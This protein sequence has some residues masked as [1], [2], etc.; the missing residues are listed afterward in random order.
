MFLNWRLSVELRVFENAAKPVS[1]NIT[2]SDMFMQ[3][4][5]SIV[6]ITA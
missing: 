3:V 6:D 1:S 5:P 4:S 2:V